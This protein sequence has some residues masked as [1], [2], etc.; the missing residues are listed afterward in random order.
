MLQR[1]PLKRP[2]LAHPSSATGGRD[3]KFVEELARKSLAI[4]PA[5]K[6]GA[7]TGKVLQGLRSVMGGS[8]EAALAGSSLSSGQTTDLSH[9]RRSAIVAFLEHENQKFQATTVEL[10]AR[11][12]QVE[13]ARQLAVRRTVEAIQ[14][15][16]TVMLNS[17][18]TEAEL[19]SA[20]EAY[21]SMFRKLG[22]TER[23]LVQNA[24][25]AC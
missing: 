23:Q 9:P 17:G 24:R 3:K 22:V 21:R 4:N 8:T 1:A 12:A 18:A 20:L 5:L 11:A 10:D 16:L 19:S 2:P 14:G 13:D 7:Q 25:A 15:L 6:N